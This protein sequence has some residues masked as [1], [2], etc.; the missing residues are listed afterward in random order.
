MDEIVELPNGVRT[1]MFRDGYNNKTG[2]DLFFIW[3]AFTISGKD[4][5]PI[6]SIRD[7]VGA[8]VISIKPTNDPVFAM[9]EDTFDV[10]FN[11]LAS[12][13][14]SETDVGGATGAFSIEIAHIDS[15]KSVGG[16]LGW[17]VKINNR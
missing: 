13:A 17:T 15:P 3:D 6:T 12:G 5:L 11:I 1:F 2:Q 16:D 14:V 7:I 10:A 8:I 9:Y 4:V